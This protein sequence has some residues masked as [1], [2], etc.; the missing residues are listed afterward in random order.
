MSQ[1]AA[2]LLSLASL[3]LVLLMTV[4]VS[5]FKKKEVEW[6]EWQVVPVHE[7]PCHCKPQ[8]IIEKVPYPVVEKIKVPV[9]HHHVVIKKK[10]RRK[11]PTRKPK[12][13][14]KKKAKKA[15][16]GEAVR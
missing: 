4:G 3:V 14:K 16:R 8:V 11:K 5:G 7:P 9:H 1:A 15:A 10:E 12:P 2:V 6:K 13:K